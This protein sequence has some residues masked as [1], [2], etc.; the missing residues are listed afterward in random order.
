[1]LA[2]LPAIASSVTTPVAA[3]RTAISLLAGA[4]GFRRR[5]TST[6]TE[7]RADALRLTAAV[8]TLIAALHRLRHGDEPI[9][10]R[11]DLAYA[12]N[13]LYMIDGAEPDPVRARAIEQYLILGIDHG[14]NASTFVARAVTSTGADL[15]AAVVAALGSLS[16]PLHGG[17]PSRALDTLDAIG[18]PDRAE[19]WVRDAVAR[20]DRI[21]GFGHPVYRTADPR[22]VMLRGVAE[23]IGGELVEFAEQVETAVEDTLAELKPGPGAAHQHR[24]VRRGRDGAAAA[25]PATCSRRPSRP[26][27]SSAG[28]P[29]RSSSTRTTASSARAAATSAPRRPSPGVD[30]SAKLRS[31]PGGA[32]P[33]CTRIAKRDRSERPRSSQIRLRPVRSGPSGRCRRGGGRA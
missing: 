4:E 12:A 20:G 27:A 6:T 15:G 30:R 21:M 29:T 28:A 26:A 19:E 13:Y 33:R 18:S 22:S 10:P 24:V 14:F 5:S 2:A 7:L 23:G 32:A 25:S 16:G 17:A 3:L 9:A 1:M 8:P 11:D 31:P